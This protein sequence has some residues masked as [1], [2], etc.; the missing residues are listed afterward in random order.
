MARIVA[1]LL[2]CL[3]LAASEPASLVNGGK[4]VVAAAKESLLGLIILPDRPQVPTTL[5]LLNS[6]EYQTYTEG[7]GTFAFYNLPQGADCCG[8]LLGCYD[9]LF[10]VAS[11]SLTTQARTHWNSFHSNTY[12]VRCVAHA[13]YVCA[14]TGMTCVVP[15]PLPWRVCHTYRT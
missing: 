9:D 1:L 6:G 10:S 11:L 14:V 3:C 5:V 12:S 4:R 2:S 15:A 8:S 13:V 7:N